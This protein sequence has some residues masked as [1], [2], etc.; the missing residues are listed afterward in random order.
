MG[1]IGVAA[2]GSS[3]SAMTGTLATIGMGSMA[4][5][6]CVVTVAPLAVVGITY[7]GVSLFR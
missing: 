6:I 3:A 1:A 7:Y 5:G 2:A 4:A